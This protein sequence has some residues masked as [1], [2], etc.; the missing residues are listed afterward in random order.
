MTHVIMLAIIVDAAS[1]IMVT[2]FLLYPSISIID[3]NIVYPT[4][5]KPYNM[6]ILKSA[7]NTKKQISVIT[8]GKASGILN[9]VATPN[10]TTANGLTPINEIIHVKSNTITYGIVL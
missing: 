3:V 2:Y 7:L 6:H 8:N 9:T 10:I 1:F 4:Y 5:V